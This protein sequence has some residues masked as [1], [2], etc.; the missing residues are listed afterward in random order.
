MFKPVV[1]IEALSSKLVNDIGIIWTKERHYFLLIYFNNKPLQ[2]AASQ[3][4]AWLYQLLFIQSRSSWWRAASLLETCTGLLLKRINRK[5]CI[6]LVHIIRIYH[7]A[8]STK[9][10]II[11]WHFSSAFHQQQ[12]EVCKDPAIANEL[13]LTHVR[14]QQYKHIILVMPPAWTIHSVGENCDLLG[15]YTA[16]SGNSL[17]ILEDGTDRLSRNVGKEPLKTGPMG[18]PETSVRKPAK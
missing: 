18:C 13:F 6:L 16:N 8:R 3:H 2:P 14:H 1:H 12:S 5:Q 7:D 4:N 9:H 10:Q 11:Q 17:P 15:Y